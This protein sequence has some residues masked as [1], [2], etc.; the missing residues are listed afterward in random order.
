VEN[1]NTGILLCG[2]G[3]SSALMLCHINCKRCIGQ[4]SNLE[5]FQV[6]GSVADVTLPESSSMLESKDQIQKMNGT[7]LQPIAYA[8]YFF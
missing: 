3:V 4:Q 7:A 6:L 2:K 5:P 1:I 8:P